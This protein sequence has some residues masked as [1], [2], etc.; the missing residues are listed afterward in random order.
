MDF[1]LHQ[2]AVA[3][4]AQRPGAAAGQDE[5]DSGE[6]VFE[7]TPL[8]GASQLALSLSD[9]SLSLSDSSTLMCVAKVAAH[10][11]T[12]NRIEASAMSPHLLSAASDD[13]TV[14][15]WDARSF[16]QP[17]MRVRVGGEVSA[18]SMGVEGTVLAAASEA[19][20]YFFDVRSLS[21]GAVAGAGSKRLGSYSEVHSDTITQ[22]RFHPT[23]QSALTS[24]SEDGLV[25]SYDTSAVNEEEA[26]GS[27][28]NTE[29]A[30]ARFGF[31]GEAMEG[32]YTLSTV[33][34][35]S[36][37]HQ[38]S[39][40]RVALFPDVRKQLGVDYL[41]D[42]VGVGSELYLV[43]GDHAGKGVVAQV[44]PGNLTRVGGLT[45]GHGATIRCCVAYPGSGLVGLGGLRL[46]TGGEDSR[47][48]SWGAGTRGGGATAGAPVIG[49]ASKAGGG[50][51]KARGAGSNVRY[52]P[53]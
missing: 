44:E 2:R 25:C 6:Y 38:P 35:M 33:E 18:L 24:A 51:M 27:V 12:I 21:T 52:K 11:S 9:N 22:L 42:C 29:C 41:V 31:F 45:E 28:L 16:T 19:S 26:L 5:M 49:S 7:V 15:I 36:V 53:Y 50:A 40:Q 30:V 48:C 39:A 46:F 47:L 37:W 23:H 20:I 43:A 1:S 13:Q 32:L 14:S 10:T 17:V 34:T 4:F 8:L 3:S